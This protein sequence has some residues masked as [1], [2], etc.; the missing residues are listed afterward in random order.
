MHFGVVFFD[1]AKA[2]DSLNNEMLLAKL[3]FSG[4]QGVSEVWFRSYLTNQREKVEVKSP[5]T[6]QNFFCNWG[7]MNYGVPQ[8]SILGPLLFIIYINNLP[9]RINSVS[10]PMLFADDTSFKISSRN[11]EDF[12]SVTIL[13][14][15]HM[16]KWF[17]ANNLVPHLDKTNIVKFVKKNE[18]HSA[19]H[20][21]CKEKYIEET[22]NKKFLG[23]QTE[24][25][26]N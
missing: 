16:I 18:S 7:T 6:A 1:L 17:A 14:P 13:V 10:E 8:V 21:G 3:H 23:L 2:F 22:V 15:S 11:F 4:I 26:T 19:L 25:H 9:M 24:N 5:H 12:S 20:I